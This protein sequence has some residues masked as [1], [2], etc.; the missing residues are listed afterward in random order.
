V[1]VHHNDTLRHVSYVM[2]ERGLTMVPVLDRAAPHRLLGV[3]SLDQLLHARLHD[4]T[5][6]SVRERQLLTRWGTPR[7]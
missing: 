7:R 5:E 6:E 4:L 1:T 3:V 2:A